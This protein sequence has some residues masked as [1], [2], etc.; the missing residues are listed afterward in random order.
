LRIFEGV[1][2]TSCVASNERFESQQPAE[3]KRTWNAPRLQ[4]LSAELAR[5]DHGENNF[6]GLGFS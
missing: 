1:V 6:D 4:S 2:M 5:G 3:Q